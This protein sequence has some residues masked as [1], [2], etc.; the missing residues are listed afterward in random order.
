MKNKTR[1]VV[2]TAMM[3]SLICVATMIVKIPTSF[4]YVN[5]GDC[6]VLLAGWTLSPLY[7]FCATAVGSALADVFSG[8]VMYAP[9]TFVIKGI[10]ALIAVYGFRLLVSKSNEFIAT[11]ISGFVAEI[12]MISGYFIF[13]GVLYGFAAS[14]V[15]IPFN[16]VQGLIGLI[17]GTLLSKVFRK[18]NFLTPKD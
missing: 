5:L 8:Y 3:A 1:G 16:G 9:I 18:N 4:G 10:M 12:I 6:F 15:N 7:G 2:I 14:T 11:V 17:L 13:E